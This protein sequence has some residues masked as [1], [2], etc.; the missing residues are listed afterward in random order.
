MGDL[1]RLNMLT[2][3]DGITEDEVRDAIMNDSRKEEI[4]AFWAEHESST[5]FNRE[6][7]ETILSAAK[8]RAEGNQIENLSAR[9][10]EIYWWCRRNF[11][12][13][14]DLNGTPF[15]FHHGKQR[16]RPEG[17]PARRVH[18]LR[19]YD[20]IDRRMIISL[21]DNAFDTFE[22]N[23][24]FFREFEVGEDALVHVKRELSK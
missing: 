8:A 1:N 10:D 22:N 16:I 17:E 20:I 9:E 5:P 6:D 18:V 14:I 7:T 3:K 21:W 23:R 11:A 12:I 13:K 15:V 4:D 2:L 19:F 24:D